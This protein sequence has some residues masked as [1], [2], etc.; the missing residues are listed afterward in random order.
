MDGCGVQDDFGGDPEP[1]LSFLAKKA[2]FGYWLCPFM[3]PLSCLFAIFL[4]VPAMGAVSYFEDFGAERPDTV[5]PITD[6]GWNAFFSNS[7]TSG[8]ASALIHNSGTTRGGLA[9]GA[10]WPGNTT[11]YLF[12]QNQATAVRSDFFFY[13]TTGVS[14]VP[15]AV[16][17]VSWNTNR[18]SFSFNGTDANVS[19]TLSLAVQIDSGSWY[20]VA[21]NYSSSNTVSFT[22]NSATFQAITFGGAG[23]A[24][25]IDTGSSATFA[26]LFGSG[27]SVTGVGFYGSIAAGIPAS[28]EPPVTAVAR[29]LRLDN[30]SIVPEPG[31]VYLAGLSLLGLAL[32]RRR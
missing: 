25:S 4:T 26:S 16:T 19:S 28:T 24:M 18:S 23:S 1:G 30:L 17:T 3:K 29:T 12:M 13:T 22:L 6:E 9:E 14:F 10:S 21:T 8:N 20:A 2:A 5:Y 31:S 7:G 32:K 11:A 15:P 27:Q